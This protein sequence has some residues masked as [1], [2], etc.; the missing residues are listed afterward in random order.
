VTSTRGPRTFDPDVI[1]N[2]ETRAWASY[3]R[4]EWRPFLKAAVTMVHEGFGMS[5]PRSVR[6]AYYVL[7]A[8]QKWAPYPDN[9]PDGARA[10]MRRFYDLVLRDSG[11]LRLDAD[12]ASGREVE[13]WRRHREHQYGVVGEEEPLVES[14]VDLYAYVY[15]VPR[16]TVRESA[17]QRV[18]AM[19]HSDAWVKAGCNLADPLLEQE[20]QALLASYRSLR[21][22]VG[23][24]AADPV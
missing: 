10:Y 1:G 24:G 21:A 9:D 5:W 16:D 19:H 22:A 17:R 12:E 20:R 3:Y 6:G 2:A 18:L 4:R 8:N 15:G 23:P 13:W 14:L 11:D 7:R